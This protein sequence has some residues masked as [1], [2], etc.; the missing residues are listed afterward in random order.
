MFEELVNC[1]HGEEKP[2]LLIGFPHLT[3]YL[4]KL[5]K[6]VAVDAYAEQR[7]AVLCLVSGFSV[8]IWSRLSASLTENRTHSH[9]HTYISLSH[10]HTL[11]LQY[12]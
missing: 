3:N 4:E 8:E 10:T 11:G 12:N 9:T 1:G 7:R 6:Q 2:R 5:C